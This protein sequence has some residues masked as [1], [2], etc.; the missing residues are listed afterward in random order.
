LCFSRNRLSEIVHD[1]KN[2]TGR[3]VEGEMWRGVGLGEKEGNLEGIWA[4]ILD[5]AMRTST[6]VGMESR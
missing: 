5:V 1:C 2:G 6:F 4:A 3:G